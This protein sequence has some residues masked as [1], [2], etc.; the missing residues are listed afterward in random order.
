MTSP[1]IKISSFLNPNVPGT[2]KNELV[3]DIRNEGEEELPH[4][5]TSVDIIPAL[6]SLAWPEVAQ[7]WITR[8]RKWPLP[9]KVENVIREGFHLVV[10]AP[11]SG[12]N[13]ECDFRISFSHAEYLLS[14]EMN[15]IQRQCYR[16]LKKYH[17]VYLS[18]EPKSVNSFHLKNIF[19][20]TIEDRGR[21]VDRKQES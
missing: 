16:C 3:G 13:P 20:R 17:R 19:L 15:D 14:L 2:F 7:D 21:D 5:D 18:T 4:L 9:A 12:G 10:K 1:A 6:R 11:K 8:P